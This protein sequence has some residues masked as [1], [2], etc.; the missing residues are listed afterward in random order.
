MLDDGIGEKILSQVATSLQND[1]PF[2][3]YHEEGVAIMGGDQEGI[4]AW[5]TLNY[6]LGKIGGTTSTK[7]Q[8]AGIMDLGGGKT[9]CKLNILKIGSTQ[10]VFEEP[11]VK[12]GD[13]RVELEFSGH[14]YVLYQHSYDGYGLMQARKSIHEESTKA[15]DDAPCLPKG[16]TLEVKDKT[17]IT[18]ALKGSALEFGQCQNLISSSVFSK[19]LK[20]CPTTPCAFDGVYMPPLEDHHEL[21]A[22]SYFFDKFSQPFEVGESF[23]IS[24][25]KSA[26]EEVCTNKSLFHLGTEGQKELSKNQEWCTDLGYMYSLLSVGYSL[27]DTRKISSVKKVNGIEIGWS[28]GCAI[29]MLETITKCSAP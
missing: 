25:L 4:F 2:P 10:I 27:P 16:T 24:Q 18:V 9:S 7:V 21:Y 14:T 11:N 28:L 19:D 22:F 8:T 29:K 1:F 5:I 15:P 12:E 17:G 23:Q 13:H 3:I 6:L 26:A 20:S